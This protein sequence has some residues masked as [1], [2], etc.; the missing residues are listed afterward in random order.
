HL[1]EEAQLLLAGEEGR[2]E[3]AVPESD[4]LRRDV[5]GDVAGALNNRIAAAHLVHAV[6]SGLGGAA[7]ENA[8]DL[9]DLRAVAG[10]ELDHHP[11][12]ATGAPRADALVL[13]RARLVEAPFDCLENRRLADAVGADYADCRFLGDREGV[14]A[15]VLLVVPQC[16][17]R[18]DH[19]PPPSACDSATM[20]CASSSACV[21]RSR[22]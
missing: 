16:Q 15:A 5:V 22:N 20:R 18:D 12:L 10:G 13:D 21:P 1:A 3:G 19:A 7:L 17:L 9:V 4:Q 11:G 2:Y 6:D 8:L 14:L